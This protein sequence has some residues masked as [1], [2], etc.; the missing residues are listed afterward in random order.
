MLGKILSSKG[1]IQLADDEIEKA[2]VLDDAVSYLNLII[3]N[4]CNLYINDSHDY[5]YIPLVYSQPFEIRGIPI[6]KFKIE[7]IE[8]SMNPFEFS[9][10]GFY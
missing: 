8:R 7:K 10:Y 1:V 4:H 9:Y 2:I 5:I 6:W 3:T